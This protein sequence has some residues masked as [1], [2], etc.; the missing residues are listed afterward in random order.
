M[1]KTPRTSTN[2]T[3]FCKAAIWWSGKLSGRWSEG[4]QCQNV[5]R[6]ERVMQKNHISFL[7]RG[8]ASTCALILDYLGL[9]S[10]QT[11]DMLFSP[12]PVFSLLALTLVALLTDCADS[13]LELVICFCWCKLSLRWLV[14]CLWLLG[15]LH[16]PFHLLHHLWISLPPRWWPLPFALLL[17]ALPISWCWWSLHELYLC[18]TCPFTFTSL[19]AWFDRSLLLLCYYII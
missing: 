17:F 19:I 16:W 14:L 2:V 15:F 1:S 3:C 8:V 7:V 9:T 5:W 6:V 13:C 10:S 4:L 18:A 11:V 12:S